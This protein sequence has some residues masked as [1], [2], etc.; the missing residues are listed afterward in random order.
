VSESKAQ[1]DF[2]TA[3]RKAFWNEV[4]SFLSGRSNRLLSWDEV[5]DK[6]R[7]RGQVYR[8][9]EAIPVE[10]IVGSVGRYRDFDR[11]FL[12]AQDRTAHRWRS[13]ARAHY[14]DV[15]LPPVKLYRVGEVY[16]VLDGNHRVSVARERGM[17]FVD[18]EVVEAQARVPFEA[19][20]DADNLEIKGEYA[21]FLER[22]RLDELR[23]DQRVEFTIA[24]G[25]ERLLEHIAV[26]RHFMGLEQQRFISPDEAVCDWHDKVYLPLVSIIRARD[27]LR[28]FPNRTDADL[29][30]WVMDHQ[31]YLRERLGP[32]VGAEQAADHF[33][34]HYTSR[35]VRRALHVLQDLVTGRNDQSSLRAD[36]TGDEELQK[37]E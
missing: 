37:P 8:G 5:R 25:Y 29:Y 20:L 12:P 19:D 14:D 23:P 26:H 36:G 21:D 27:T 15:G 10:R 4:A 31:H 35:P 32:A 34:D 16:F 24:G 18:A 6:L 3:R 28:D 13:I 33:A 7:V 30:L 2:A 1:I 9:L 17:A 22:T 11:A